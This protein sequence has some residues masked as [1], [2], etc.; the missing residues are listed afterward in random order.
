MKSVNILYNF[1]YC[2]VGKIKVKMNRDKKSGCRILAI[3]K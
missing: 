3:A 2:Y 1:N